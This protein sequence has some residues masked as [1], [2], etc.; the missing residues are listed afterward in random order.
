MVFNIIRSDINLNHIQKTTIPDKIM[1]P[2]NDLFH[3]IQSMSKAEK[4]H[5]NLF[6]S[7]NTKN[8]SNN[9][10][11]L[12]NAIEQQKEYNEEKIRKKFSNEVFAKKLAATKYLLFELILKSLR[13]FQSGKTINSQLNAHLEEAEILFSKALY[14]PCKKVLLKARKLATSNH[15]S[16][17]LQQIIF[18]EKELTP[19]LFGGKGKL[20]VQQQL[21]EIHTLTQQAQNEATFEKLY[22]CMRTYY[23]VCLTKGGFCNRKAAL[24][25][26]Q[27][28]LLEKEEFALT[29]Q[30][31]RCYFEIHGL[32]A[33]MNNQFEDAVSE[34]E[35]LKNLWDANPKM[36][37]TDY[38]NFHRNLSEYLLCSL[39][40][41]KPID[42]NACIEELECGLL[43]N[44][45]ESQKYKA[46]IEVIRF[47]FAIGK[48]STTNL[49]SVKQNLVETLKQNESKLSLVWK[50]QAWYYLGVYCFLTGANDEAIDWIHQVQDYEK[51]GVLPGIQRF[52]QLLQIPVHYELKNYHFLEYQLRS[53]LRYLKK[54]G[55]A[56]KEEEIFLGL[57]RK[58]LHVA[59]KKEKQTQFY[60]I[61]NLLNE[62]TSSSL[63]LPI[64]SKVLK[65]WANQYLPQQKQ[66]TIL[67]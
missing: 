60:K 17:Y 32:Y 55:I 53:T 64:G 38:R 41:Q 66:S 48:G 22:L 15:R 42:F 31:K 16:F 58:C 20:A 67:A 34:F 23:E 56:N 63:T 46:Q 47:C 9:Y 43:E 54:R 29:F 28:P 52:I 57:V 44:N 49:E 45:I 6:A 7:Q 10:I 11:K 39:S 36:K 2:S 35:K 19:Y 12:F 14:K 30:A 24:K 61:N 65:N 50:I 40:I 59:T 13:N 51:T 1:V 62:S 25:I 18:W 37:Q 8:G 3:L 27:H 33:K 21:E 4:R 26:M 5:F